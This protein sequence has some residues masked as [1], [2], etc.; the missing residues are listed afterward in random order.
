M[1]VKDKDSKEFE[2]IKIGCKVMLKKEVLDTKGRAILKAVKKEDPDVKEI[3]CGRYIE[4]DIDQKDSRQALKQAENLAQNI[5]H[6]NLI[7][8]F[9]LEVLEESEALKESN[10]NK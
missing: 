9:H 4:L 6:N 7:E 3:R 1:S 2:M 5:L 10:E 8:S